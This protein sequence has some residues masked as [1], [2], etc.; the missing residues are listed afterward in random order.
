MGHSGARAGHTTQR[1][2]RLLGLE[3]GVRLSSSASLGTGVR[4]RLRVRGEE[5]LRW[6]EERIFMYRL[7]CCSLRGKQLDRMLPVFP[8]ENQRTMK[9]R[10]CHGSNAHQGE[11]RE[12]A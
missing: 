4:F 6:G 10:Q 9:R 11:E 12:C 7:G 3:L 2:K 1:A 8:R 5:R